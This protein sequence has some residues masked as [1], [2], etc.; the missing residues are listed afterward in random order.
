ME[1]RVENATLDMKP[2]EQH[3]KPFAISIV[4]TF[5][6]ASLMWRFLWN[7]EALVLSTCHSS[8]YAVQRQKNFQ[9]KFRVEVERFYL[10]EMSLTTTT[11]NIERINRIFSVCVFANLL[12]WNVIMN[13]R[14]M[15]MT[16]IETKVELSHCQ[17]KVH[18][19][20]AINDNIP[21]K[22]AD[23]NDVRLCSFTQKHKHTVRD[24]DANIRI[25]KKKNHPFTRLLTKAKAP[26]I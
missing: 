17:K 13:A 6:S 5:A 8:K 4:V 22:S 1:W 26:C 2:L 9:L 21:P 23:V 7:C 24:R 11:K 14:M 25:E 12:L 18:I 19:H 3:L 20:F 16:T 15:M 10:A